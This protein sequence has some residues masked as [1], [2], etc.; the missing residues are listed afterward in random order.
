ML[1]VLAVALGAWA[2]MGAKKP[3]KIAR[4]APTPVATA[5]VVARDMPV[6]ITALGAAQAWGSV[7]VRAQVSGK[8]KTVGFTEGGEVR[9]GQVLAEI[10]PAPF[11]ALLTQ[12]QGALKRDTAML[13]SAKVDLARYQ[14]LA[15]QDSI[16]R[17]QVDTQAALVKQYEGVV[18]I[19]QGQVAT[20][21]INLGYTRIVSPISGRA[22]VRLVDPGNLVSATDTTGVTTVNQITPIAVTFTVP[23]GDFQ[24][25][26]DASSAFS[27]ALATQA[28]S[29]DTGA[30]LGAGALAIADNHVDAATGSVALKA[31]FPNAD[32]RLWPGQFVN[33]RLTLQTLAHALTVPAVAVNQGPKGAFVYIVGPDGKAEM[34]PVTV[35]ATQ[36]ATAV[37]QSGVKEGE[38]VVTDGQMSLAPGAKVAVHAPGGGGKRPA[39]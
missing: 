13:D 17:Q 25:L 6:A 37:I 24:R 30:E 29:Q 18:Q 22:G 9:A 19:D 27:R 12:A 33:V 15:S 7:V 8:L 10:D 39:K 28:F 4:K 26:S 35:A 1:A 21:R 14:T 32:R 23:Q 3:P 16:A 11:Q 38:T 20:A 36:D 5:K 2:V 31:R 34:R